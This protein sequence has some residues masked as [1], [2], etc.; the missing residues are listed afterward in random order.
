MLWRMNRRRLEIESLRDTML[1]ASGRLD[2]KAGGTPFDLMSQPSIP[3]RSVYGFIERGRMPAMLSAFDFSSPDQHA[4]MRFVTTVPQ[5]ALFFLNS[6][7]VAE[8]ARYLAGRVE[9]ANPSNAIRQLYQLLF[10]RDPQQWELEAGLQFIAQKPG[11]AP[12]NDDAESP[13]QYGTGGAGNFTPFPIFL[14]DRWQGGGAI[15]AA[16]SGKAPVRG[17][18]HRAPV[19]YRMCVMLPTDSSG[20]TSDG[21][22]MNISMA[23]HA[24]ACLM[25]PNR[26]LPS[27]TGR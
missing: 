26:H 17:H 22:A 10:A 20:T 24:L 9:P 15:P 13:W 21:R 16:Q 19:T 27:A 11:D 4:P 23:R 12:T 1:V 2:S 25:K 7:F 5:Q 8:Q 3:R 6:P 18:M 14:I